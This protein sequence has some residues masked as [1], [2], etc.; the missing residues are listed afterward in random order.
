MKAIELVLESI[1]AEFPANVDFSVQ[2][3]L[4]FRHT[5][6]YTNKTEY[7]LWRNWIQMENCRYLKFTFGKTAVG[8]TML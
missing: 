4:V 3:T 2:K 6:L 8:E 1:I 5:S 7:R